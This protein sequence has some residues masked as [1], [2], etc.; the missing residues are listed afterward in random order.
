[1]AVTG[2]IAER[3]AI[4]DQEASRWARGVV[5]YLRAV[6]TAYGATDAGPYFTATETYLI[7]VGALHV[8]RI[9]LTVE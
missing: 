7:K 1:M 2:G 5:E 3:Q 8:A 4:I 9:K 6:D